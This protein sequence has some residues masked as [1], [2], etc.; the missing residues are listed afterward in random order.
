[1]KSNTGLV[2]YAKAQLGK[3]YWY[4][5]F[6]NTATKSLLA[7]KTKQY[8]GHY[9][10]ARMSKYNSQ[11]GERVH[12]CVGL[13]KGYLWSETAT[14]TPKYNSSQDVSA[15]GML[16][17]CKIQGKI[18]TIPE[19]PGV[20]VFFSGHVGVYIGDGWVIEAKGFNYGV[21]KTRLNSGNWTHWGKCPFI[22]Y[23]AE[24][25]VKTDPGANK[26]YFMKYTGTSVSIADAL[27]SLGYSSTYAYRKKIASANN[28]KY[29][30]GS[31][32][33]NT[34]MLSLLKKGTLIKP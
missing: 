7:S 27:K 22:T 8:P 18:A 6:G 3:P 4:G 15:N 11:I 20:L 26:A 9:T 23:P 34:Q 17:K 29:Y 28:I 24:N 14:S 32:K 19:I 31:A 2:N 16:G 30:V 25:T 1:M 10:D 5:T 13:I 33:Q 21:V 12:D